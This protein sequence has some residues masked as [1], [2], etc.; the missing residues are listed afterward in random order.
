MIPMW[1]NNVLQRS[2]AS[3]LRIVASRLHAR[4]AE[5][6]VGPLRLANSSPVSP[7]LLILSSSLAI[8]PFSNPSP[9][10]APLPPARQL[11]HLPFT[12]SLL[13]LAPF[14]P[15]IIL[16]GLCYRDHFYPSRAC[17]GSGISIANL[18]TVLAVESVLV[19]A[20][21]S[22]VLLSGGGPTNACTRAREASFLTF[23]QCSARAG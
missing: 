3:Q 10:Q 6:C 1:S 8:A 18:S 21:C 12:V 23:R 2:R 4:P 22:E 15:Y 7:A 9:R 13:T 19:I 16:T 17:S 11:L 20:L 14:T 5:H